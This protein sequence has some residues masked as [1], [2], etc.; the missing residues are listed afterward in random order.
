MPKNVVC[1][2]AY[3][4]TI[5][6]GE[7]CWEDYNDEYNHKHLGP[8]NKSENSRGRII[9]GQPELTWGT[10]FLNCFPSKSAH[11]SK[12]KKGK[13]LA[14]DWA[15]HQKVSKQKPFS[16]GHLLNWG[17]LTFTWRGSLAN[18][19]EESMCFFRSKSRYSKTKYRRFSLCTTSCNLSTK[20]P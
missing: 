16:K 1:K 9:K 2:F 19:G 6:R 8:F 13:I 12:V 17:K 3:D 10:L 18:S 7:L 15:D 14:T 20:F 11:H 4:I 5:V